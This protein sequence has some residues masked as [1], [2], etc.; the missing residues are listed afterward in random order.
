[1]KSKWINR[2]ILIVLLSLCALG[3]VLALGWY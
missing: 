1:M 2:L 3:A